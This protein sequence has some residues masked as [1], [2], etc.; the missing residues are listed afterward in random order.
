MRGSKDV[1]RPGWSAAALQKLVA[2]IT[3][4]VLVAPSFAWAGT[5]YTL[6]WVSTQFNPRCLTPELADPGA[7]YFRVNQTPLPTYEVPGEFAFHDDGSESNRMEAAFDSV[8]LG[9]GMNDFH[10]HVSREGGDNTCVDA[11]EVVNLV[12]VPLGLN[13]PLFDIRRRGVAF[14]GDTTL[15]L[16]L[17]EINPALAR[18]IE[19][20]LA[21]IA[22]ERKALVANAPRVERLAETMDL[23]QQLDTELKDLV[24]RPLDEIS[25]TDLDAILDRYKD[26]VGTETRAAMEQLVDDLKKSVSDLEAELARLIDEFGAQADQ[27][28]DLATQD[29]RAEGWDPDDTGAYA[30]GESEVPWVEVPD[31]AEVE[32]AF[33]EGRDPYAAYADAVL[34]ALEADVSG[35]VVVLRADFVAN[36]RAWRDNSAALEIALRDRMGVS[37]AE[38]NAFLNAQNRITGFVRQFM[39][40]SDWFEDSPV[41]ADLRVVVDTVLK[42]RFDALA[43]QMK[44]SLNLWRGD[45]LDLEKTQLYQTISAFAGAMSTVGEG[46][47][48]Y[49]GVMQTLVHATTRLGVGFVPVMGPALDLCEAVTG[50]AFC[51]PSGQELSDEERIFSG[52]GFGV[53]AIGP[54]WRVV[55]TSGGLRPSAIRVAGEIAEIEEAFAQIVKT[56]RVRGYKGLPGAITTKPVDIFEKKAA[57]FLVDDGRSLVGVGDDGVRR[58]LGILKESRPGTIEGMAPDFVSVS[59]GHKLILSEAKGGGTIPV[60]DVRNQLTN[61]M[62]AVTKKGLAGDVERVELIMEQGAKFNPEK[63]TVKDGYLFDAETGKTVTLK[64]FNKFIMVIRL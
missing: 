9:M 49:A 35:R 13:K 25:R 36:V 3:A 28:A 22:K 19:I 51:L 62:E 5:P 16:S 39:D 32:G 10:F 27:V 11:R 18:D 56:N 30:L 20:L 58:V 59:S 33:E 6:D 29:A 12:S 53:A 64:G 44:D 14:S 38:T 60:S 40:A 37:L 34:A 4:V 21:E 48:A 24:S 2:L 7:A 41:P 17:A 15:D 54:M 26:V 42:P 55:K 43:D 47:E 46:V 57:K 8:L 63:F 23:L 52:L 31:I 61:A 45:G 50:K 1:A